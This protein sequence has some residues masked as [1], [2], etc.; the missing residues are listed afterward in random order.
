MT[1]QSPKEKIL[2]VER[3]SKR[4]ARDPALVRRYG[5]SDILNSIMP[6]TTPHSVSLREGEFWALRDL[7]LELAEG[8][9]LGVIGRNGSGK[10]TLLRVIQGLTPPD[11]GKVSRHVNTAA[12]IDIGAGFEPLASGR[13]AIWIEGTL[14]G[15][16]AD[17]IIEIE[18]DIIDFA[19]LGDVIDAPL[20]T[21]STGMQLR[22]GYAIIAHL[23]PGLLLIDEVLAVGDPAFQRKC[24]TY[25]LDYK[26]S[27]GALVLVS[28]DLW[29]I[30]ALCDR[31]LVLETG[32]VVASGSP[33]ETIN[34]YI[35]FME[36][37][38]DGP[39]M[40]STT[41]QGSPEPQD[42]Q[43]AEAFR[44]ARLSV[45]RLVVSGPD[46]GPAESGG[47]VII[48]I[49][50]TNSGP[51]V[52]SVCT[53]TI[54]AE[55]TALRVLEIER[56]GDPLTIEPGT[57]KIRCSIDQLELLARCYRLGVEFLAPGPS[58]P[59]GGLQAEHHERMAI[60]EPSD[61]DQTPLLMFGSIGR[62]DATWRTLGEST[63]S[64]TVNGDALSLSCVD[65]VDDVGHRDPEDDPASYEDEQAD[66]EHHQPAGGHAH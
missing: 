33:E 55:D 20:S 32:E 40:T 23:E 56:R 65:P 14:L 34:F 44:T 38:D 5:M 45:E 49:H 3:L 47:S 13:E 58:A 35:D 7:S 28:H 61:E 11:R 36:T 62:L 57:S 53:V 22:L 4:Y 31:C 50:V 66:E 59:G 64:P 27:G 15:L 21:Y 1:D 39:P 6:K 63:L 29:Q 16:G 54:D 26:R 30:R 48:D 10:T 24:V 41:T 46:G 19:E 37:L 60:S 9:A 12:L 25:L 51:P 42:S 2:A 17:E 18:H 8:E 52:R 43:V